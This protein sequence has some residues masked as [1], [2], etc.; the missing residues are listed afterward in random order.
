MTDREKHSSLES[1]YLGFKFG[2]IMTRHELRWIV[3]GYVFSQS[4][5]SKSKP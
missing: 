2:S 1:I 4:R 3:D 5:E